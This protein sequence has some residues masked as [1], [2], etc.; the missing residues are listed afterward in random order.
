M[1]LG[2]YHFLGIGVIPGRLELGSGWCPPA[3]VLRVWQWVKR[4]GDAA[5]IEVWPRLLRHTFATRLAEDPQV[6]MRTW[7]ELMNH[8]DSSQFRR[9]AAASD[10]GLRRAVEGL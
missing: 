2:G 1:G 3:S 10:E 5:G 8:V 9:Y 4:A 6:D 7:I